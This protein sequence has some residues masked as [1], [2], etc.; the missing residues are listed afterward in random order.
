MILDW[1]CPLIPIIS[2]SER[3]RHEHCCESEASL[4]CGVKRCLQT[5]EKAANKPKEWSPSLDPADVVRA[6]LSPGLT[7]SCAGW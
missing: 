1:A 2:A 4:C 3:L 7:T 6:F 5:K